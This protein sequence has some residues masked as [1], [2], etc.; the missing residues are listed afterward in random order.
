MRGGTLTVTVETGNAAFAE[1]G[2][3]SIVLERVAV[4]VE[5]GQPG[6]VSDSN[7]NTVATWSFRPDP[8]DVDL[9]DVD[10]LPEALERAGIGWTASTQPAVPPVHKTASRNDPDGTSWLVTLTSPG[11]Q[12]FHVDYW[13]GSRFEDVPDGPAV[14]SCLFLD[15]AF[16]EDEPFAV[17]PELTVEALETIGRSERWLRDVFGDGYERALE[18]AYE[19]DR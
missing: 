17:M 4:R 14:V 3:L 10:G 15:V 8:T 16:M 1:P 9:T 2:E 13:T 12:A 6:P 18:L 5:D 19:H 7:G 11:R